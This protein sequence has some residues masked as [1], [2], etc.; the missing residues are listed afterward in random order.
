MPQTTPGLFSARLGEADSMF[1]SPPPAEKAEP[2]TRR[3]TSSIGHAIPRR[4]GGPFGDLRRGDQP[5]HRGAESKID[6]AVGQ[7]QWYHFGVGAPP[8]LVYFS[9]SWDVYWGYGLL[10]HGHF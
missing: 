5:Q 2:W 6:L 3:D 8:I 4:R 9:G 1:D 7:N 10:T